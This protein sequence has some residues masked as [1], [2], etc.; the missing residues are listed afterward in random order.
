MLSF[1]SLFLFKLFSIIIPTLMLLNEWVCLCI[2]CCGQTYDCSVHVRFLLLLLLSFDCIR[3]NSRKN[4]RF[5]SHNCIKHNFLQMITY[6]I[7]E[8]N[9]LAANANEI[10]SFVF[11][12]EN[13]SKLRYKKLHTWQS[14]CELNI[15]FFFLIFHFDIKVNAKLCFSLW[16]KLRL[17]VS[18]L[19]DTREW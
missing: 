3:F 2:T 9:S 1:F 17:Y 16:S 11:S 14:M 15:K 10:C 19:M 4:R 8:R 12:V 7:C 18:L 5:E 6:M 13:R